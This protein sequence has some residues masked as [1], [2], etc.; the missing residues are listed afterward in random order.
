MKKITKLSIVLTLILVFCS[1]SVLADDVKG[2][3][4]EEDTRLIIGMGIMSGYEDGTF[5]P[6]NEIT[7]AEFVT[8]LMR[9]LG[10]D[11]LY[12]GSSVFSDMD[13]H[14]ATGY[15]NQANA[16]QIAYGND[17]GTF[18]PNTQVSCQQAIAFLSNALGYTEVAKQKGGYPNGYIAVGSEIGLLKGVPVA[19]DAPLTRGEVTKFLS[20]A[21]NAKTLEMNFAANE[22]SYQQGSTLLDCIG[23]KIYKGIVTAAWG[24]SLD[25][26]KPEN[27][28]QIYLD[29]KR[30]ET[31]FD[32]GI[33]YLGLAVEAYV[34]D[35]GGNDEVIRYVKAANNV[36]TVSVYTEDIISV[37][38]GTEVK[39][40]EGS[41]SKSIK[42]SPSFVVIKNG[43]MLKSSEMGPAMFNFNEGKIIF[44]DSD[45][46]RAYDFALAWSWD[47]YVV[48]H[49]SGNKIY[50]E[51]NS[52]IDLSDI[53]EEDELTILYDGEVISID[54]I[55][56]GDV[57]AVAKNAAATK[58]RIEV[59]R[60]KKYGTVTGIGEAEYK[61]QG[62]AVYF[63]VNSNDYEETYFASYR[64]DQ[65]YAK[66]SSYF[67]KPEI[68]SSGV[69]YLNASGE[70]VAF[71]V[72]AELA[73]EE[74]TTDV[75]AAAGTAKKK[76]GYKYGYFSKISR[77]KGGEV[78]KI[79]ILTD[80][81]TFEE[82]EVTE[83]LKFG[84]YEDGTYAVRK[85]DV[86]DIY[87]AY[88]ETAPQVIKYKL[89]DEGKLT[90]LCLSAN[91]NNTEV[92]GGFREARTYAFANNQL[93]QQYVVDA[94][95]ICFYIPANG[96]DDSW[97]SSK[98]VT[99]LKT[100][101]SYKVTLYD[102]VDGSVG[103]VL[104][105][106][107]L[108]T[109]R[110][111]YLLDYVNSPVMLIDS[112]YEKYD[113][114]EGENVKV[115]AGWQSGEYKEVA[116]SNTLENNSDVASNLK[117]G[118]LIQYLMNNDMR[119]F[120]RTKDLSE[121][122]IV[123]NSICDFKNLGADFI[124]WDY[125]SLTDVNAR[126]KVYKGTIDYIA[127]DVFYVTIDGNVY[128]AALHGGTTIMKYY[129][130]TE[131]LEK[132]SIED[133]ATGSKVIVRQRYNNTRDVFILE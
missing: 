118:M 94:T 107:T 124:M 49:I 57:V 82:F 23:Y 19:Y 21:L 2:Y 18:D 100:G 69:M 130:D 86:I 102:I 68:G 109:V 27:K 10:W 78:L 40:S 80:S 91:G 87:T 61:N 7:R 4:Y 50:C 59:I 24:G 115:V 44:V 28:Y 127:D 128:A 77:K 73:G 64:Y 5:R 114:D 116:V 37:T 117:K 110:Y 53:K 93:E 20:N 36:E 96:G 55:K 34:Y 123:F 97:K 122:L 95:T 111:K 104:Y 35:A 62:N 43:D 66:N 41:T 129:K 98:S 60:N 99:M 72:G 71:A 9:T 79:E 119:A 70:I 15:V 30:Y 47:E 54:D 46:N 22:I 3:K 76:D 132:G 133:I 106:P 88:S 125:S 33:E 8:L 92:W 6:D 108:S 113:E 12:G 38:L 26:N 17:D 58:I 67:T 48:D 14:W 121:E 81:N 65:E 103:A 126:I 51:Y 105:R 42:L 101:S 85:K 25:G 112:V 131:T 45:G 52:V 32:N 29:G 120:A 90:E 56:Q 13:G 75:E 83:K 63:K 74:V 11:G 1:A 89:D 16:I 84:S 31:S 39:Y